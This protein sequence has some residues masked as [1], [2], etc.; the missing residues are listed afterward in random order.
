MDLWRGFYHLERPSWT[1]FSFSS[2]EPS[3]STK[4][5]DRWIDRNPTAATVIISN[6]ITTLAG[7]IQHTTYHDTTLL[8]CGR[9][10]VHVDLVYHHTIN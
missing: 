7:G 8:L 6:C 1:E 5:Y 3:L 2:Q 9:M 4:L 10:Y